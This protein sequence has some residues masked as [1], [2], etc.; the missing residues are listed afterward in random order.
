MQATD[1]MDLFV[2]FMTQYFD[3]IRKVTAH[4]YLDNP[5]KDGKAR[6]GV[7]QLWGETE[8]NRRARPARG[9]HRSETC[10]GFAGNGN[11]FMILNLLQ[12]SKR[13]PVSYTHCIRRL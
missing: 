1:M 3:L 6:R 11:G 4:R 9:L 13:C 7:E 10:G 5:K 2:E 8:T 12:R